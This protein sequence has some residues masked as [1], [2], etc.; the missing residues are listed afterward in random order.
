VDND[1]LLDLKILFI[2]KIDTGKAIVHVL[3]SE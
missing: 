2:I 1:F 3:L